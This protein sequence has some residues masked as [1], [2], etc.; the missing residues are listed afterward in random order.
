MKQFDKL[1]NFLKPTNCRK[2]G[3]HKTKRTLKMNIK[4]FFY[5]S[6]GFRAWFR[7][8]T[9]SLTRK[10]ATS[11]QIALGVAI[12]VFIT[13]I[14]LIG[15]HCILAACISY[16][17]SANIVSALI[18]TLIGNPWTF[19]F[20]WAWT[21]KLG[22]FILYQKGIPPEH[23]HLITKL[24]NIMHLSLHEIVD[25][26]LQVI[27][28]MTIGGVPT[29]LLFALAFYFIVKYNVDKYRLLRKKIL[30]KKRAE[31]RAQRIEKIKHT[32]SISSNKEQSK[33][34]KRRKK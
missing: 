26:A 1:K 33:S 13:F 22:N 4:E 2:R 23:M 8:M 21:L 28:P 29:G 27:Y 14:P 10:P 16:L 34:K 25:L 17:L 12:G 19:P 32:F 15:F 7:Y 5:P 6:I 9:L 31:I 18:G 3:I 24:H 30:E 11:H 20:I